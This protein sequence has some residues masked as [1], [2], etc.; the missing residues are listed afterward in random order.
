[1]TDSIAHRGPD[2]EGFW[3]EKDNS[4][5][6][7][8][9]RLSIL[10]LSTNGH[11]PMEVDDNYFITFNGEIYNYLELK[12]ELQK[13]GY[14]FKTNSDTEVLI[15]SYKHWGENFLDRLDGM[16]AFALYNRKEK[17]LLCAR[18]RFGEKPF[19]YYFNGN[20]FIFGSEMKEI[21]ASGVKRTINQKAVF[22]YLTFD[23]VENP[24]D[25]SETFFE[26]I[27]SLPASHK[28]KVNHKGTLSV[29]SYWEL[30]TNIN[31]SIKKEDAIEKFKELFDTSINRRLR[32]DVK[33]G[34]SLSGGVDSSSLVSSIMQNGTSDFNTFTA[35]FNDDAYDESKYVML[36]NEKYSFKSHYCEPQPEQLIQ[37][38]DNVFHH[39]EEPFGSSSIVAQW[40][41]MK[42]AKKNNTKV[43]LDGQ[44]ADETLAGYFKYFKPFLAEKRFSLKEFKRELN[45]IQDH[46]E[47][48]NFFTKND[49]IRMYSPKLYNSLAKGTRKLRQSS[50]ASDL[51]LDFKQKHLDSETLFH[52]D[53]ELNSFLHKDIFQYGLGKLLRFSDR[54]AMAHSI[55]VR[56]PYLSHELVEFVFS[57]PSNYKISS[58]WTKLILRESM[59]GRVPNEILYRK[60][61]K[62]FQAPKNWMQHSEIQKLI[63]SSIEHLQ[64]LNIIDTP[65]TAHHW[66]YIMISKLF[67]NE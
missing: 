53:N 46:L 57:L 51:N 25:K 44:G 14:I 27:K 1:M 18:D 12:Y 21:F 47:D 8:H 26:G 2:G 43:L 19:Y 42:L 40:E 20:T 64:K 30:N 13:H 63:H 17:T 36:L 6:F 56:L 34:A 32:S 58:G 11:Q 15:M 28:I 16:F 48:K 67:T 45:A 62:G 9:R 54:N 49:K 24:N 59:K 7:G 4:I 61:K 39:Q 31:E 10:D 22:R 65:I 3:I 50:L 37:H 5:G 33:V 29:S 23:L 52:T 41:V 55:E 35:K 60:D 38:L 66:K